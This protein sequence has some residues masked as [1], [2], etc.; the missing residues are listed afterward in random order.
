MRRGSD[1]HL[2]FEDDSDLD[3]P[4]IKIDEKKRRNSIATSQKKKL[5][6]DKKYGDMK[7]IYLHG[8]GSK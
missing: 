6:E 4:A 8:K 3:L 2:R 7:D 1:N 5:S